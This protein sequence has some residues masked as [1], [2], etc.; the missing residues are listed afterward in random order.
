MAGLAMA[1]TLL[2]DG[3]LMWAVISYALSGRPLTA[4]DW[5][6]SVM[7]VGALAGALVVLLRLI[8]R[9]PPGWLGLLVFLVGLVLPGVIVL[10][11]ALSGPPFT[12]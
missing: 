3:M 1:A 7:L 9:R 8:G 11:I 2:V 5:V 4:G 10:L 12:A 6:V